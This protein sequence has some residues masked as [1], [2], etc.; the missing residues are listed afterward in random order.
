MTNNKQTHTD[1][2]MVS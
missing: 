1:L 2:E